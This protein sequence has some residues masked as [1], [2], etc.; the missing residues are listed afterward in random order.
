MHNIAQHNVA[1]LFN[2]EFAGDGVGTGATT[3][4][5][6]SKSW[7]SWQLSA[8]VCLS[9]HHVYNMCAHKFHHRPCMYNRQNLQHDEFLLSLYK[10]VSRSQKNF[11]H[12]IQTNN[13]YE[14]IRT[15]NLYICSAWKD[16]S[17]EELVHV[18]FVKKE[19]SSVPVRVLQK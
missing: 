9:R 6:F 8:K 14:H 4:L 3:V 2:Q 11:S 15:Y 10:L 7:Q 19:L 12:N 18:Y 5:Q 17:K 16:P 1:L 13:I